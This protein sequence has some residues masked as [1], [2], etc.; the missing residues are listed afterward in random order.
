MKLK[1]WLKI[2]LFSLLGLILVLTA[3]LGYFY[4]EFQGKY[5]VD[6]NKY[7]HSIG[8][9]SESNNF[10]RCSDKIVGWYASAA[11]YVPIY[12]GSKYSFKRHIKENYIHSD[13]TTN[14][15]LNL[16]FVINCQG[17]VGDMEVNQIDLNYQTTEFSQKLVEQL[18]QLS[19]R[20]ENWEIP[21]TEE[22]KDYYMYLI[23]KIEDG[24]IAEILP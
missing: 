10:K 19:S 15:F 16:R 9:L 13:T 23:Y 17:E 18:I 4:Y 14:G 6:E 8:H 11:T 2:S 21:E 1:K 3:L 24:K 5:R 20:K 7:P 22:P 12:K